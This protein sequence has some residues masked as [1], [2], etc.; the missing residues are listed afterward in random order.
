MK[1]RTLKCIL[2]LA[3]GVLLPL[4]AFARPVHDFS[5]EDCHKPDISF[6]ELGH[7]TTNVCLQCHNDKIA[8][9]DASNLFS[10][11]PVGVTPGLQNSHMWA[12]AEDNS[13]AG[14]NA[15]TSPEFYGR[16]SVS[17]GLV[18]C[19]RCHD[20]HG[21]SDN[22]NLLRLGSV[23][24]VCRE[25]HSAWAGPVSHALG[26]H[27]LVADYAA[28]AV[29]QPDSYLTTPNNGGGQGS[30]AL[31]D[32]GVGCSSCHAAHFVDSDSATADIAGAVQSAGDGRLLRADGAQGDQPSALCQA[33]HTYRHHGDG[34]GE[35][36]GCLSCH[37]GHAFN[38]GNPN[39][40]VLRASVT[41]SSYGTVTG[42]DYSGSA[43]I[44]DAQKH[45]LWNDGVDGTADGYCEKCHGDAKDIIGHSSS[46]ICTECHAHN[47]SGAIYSF[48]GTGCSG[49]HLGSGDVDDY[50]F[51]NGTT[52]QVD[53]A[54][55]NATGHGGAGFDSCYYCHGEAGHDDP[56][57]PFRLANTTGPD[58][59]NGV[60]W[61]CHKTGSTG[62]DPDGS[63]PVPL[64]NGSSKADSYH[65]GSKHGNSDKGGRFCW[66][67]HDPHGDSN[68]VM[69]QDLLAT[70]SDDFGLPVQTAPVVFTSNSTGTDF[71]KSSAPYDGIC[72]VC[73]NG[74]DHYT[75]NSGDG[76][77]AGSVCTTCH[78]HS[79]DDAP[80]QAFAPAGG[81]VDCH[82]GPQDNGD[83]VP[84][85]GRRGMMAEFPLSNAHAHYGNELNDD[86]CLV[87][88][89]TATHMNG[90]V[91][92]VDPD[93]GALYS[94]VQ[95]SD[96]TSD[97]DLSNFCANC[98]DANGAARLASALNP[99]GN[100]NVPPDVASKFLGSLQWNEFYGDI[101]FGSEGSQRPSN[102]HH[103]I[104]DADQAFGSSKIECLDCHGAHTSAASQ[105]VADPDNTLVAWSG[106]SNDFCLA[107]HD[108][109]SDPLNYDMP[110]GVEQHTFYTPV[111]DPVNTPGTSCGTGMIYD[112]NDQCIDEAQYASW[113][114]DGTYCDDGAYGVDFNCAEFDYDGGDCTGTDPCIG[115]DCPSLA[116]IDSCNGYNRD[117]WWIGISWSNSAH[118]GGS[119]RSWPGYV[120][121]PQAPSYVL[122]CISCH[123]PHGSYSATNPTGNPYMIR[124]YVDGSAFVDDGNRDD[125]T[126]GP[127]WTY[128]SAGPVVVPV[129][130]GGSGPDMTSLCVKCHAK[131]QTADTF[132]HQDCNA[133][134]NC[135]SHGRAFGENDWEGG[136]N[137]PFCP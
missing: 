66:D 98:H 87:C 117:P 23:E 57:N 112:C 103:D 74:A 29:P 135:H 72:N 38:A 36:I 24:S 4:A 7:A 46:D 123:D 86:T 43:A 78:P 13:A 35:Q 69:V 82:A 55:W 85:G 6:T 110:T 70:R 115:N 5:C 31:V 32:G 84:V 67:C 34:S 119:K 92:L 63:G 79:V 88:H 124:D 56:T 75:S 37:S 100:G 108:G 91:E 99:F 101:C 104:S 8:V 71:A 80:N 54:Q 125:P 25:C 60:C 65:Y 68:I 17:R 136:G 126:L 28:V 51:G 83:G 131:W 59:P 15:P 18:T 76:H 128:G 122:D 11:Y 134:N 94:F 16:Y 20:P 130:V 120:L 27:P 97:P 129:E 26:T 42:L 41:T 39:Y 109:G 121:D 118:G 10:S 73:H 116:G 2:L 53:Q 19:S 81:C 64:V 132:Y 30:I 58:G 106:T 44:D 45:S 40:Y 52:A 90:Y 89:S 47:E 62:F 1:I 96:L 111:V 48:E 12:A 77:N 50:V 95:P 14:A 105:P 61:S 22:Q 102:S 9:S 127:V 133:C 49:C 21:A 114:G 113:I 137:A 93:S 3:C 33:C 107:C